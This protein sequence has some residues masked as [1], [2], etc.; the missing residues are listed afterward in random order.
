MVS[1]SK[2]DCFS[3]FYH[4]TIKYDSLIFKSAEAAWQA[5]KTLDIKERESFQHMTPG[6]A[7]RLGRQVKLRKDWEKIKYD[8]MVDVCLVKFTQNKDLGEQLLKTGDDLI[9]ENTTGWH[10]NLWGNCHC[11]K[12][13]NIKG[14]NL[15]GKALMEVREK[16]K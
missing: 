14:Q 9:E 10:D 3:N 15:L 11:A 6:N 13:K 4:C 12:C 5:Q 2:G 16:L 7:K 8:L 1:F